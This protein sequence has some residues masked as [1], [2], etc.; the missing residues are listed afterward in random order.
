M[1]NHKNGSM[2]IC[3]FLLITLFYIVAVTIY[4]FNNL[5]ASALLILISFFAYVAFIKIDNNFFSIIALLSLSLFF[6]LGLATL[7]LI[8]LQDHIWNIKTWISFYM[9]YTFFIFS[10]YCLNSSKKYFITLLT[11]YKIIIKKKGI[12][13][14]SF[15]VLLTLLSLISF[16]YVVWMEGYIPLF[17]TDQFSYAKFGAETSIALF[18]QIS[19]I[20]P[21]LAFY[22]KSNK[23]YSMLERKI[24]EI[25]I[26]L[27]L[28]IC[29]F[30]KS[31]DFLLGAAIIFIISII[32]CLMKKFKNK[33]LKLKLKHKIIVLIL[34]ILVLFL[35]IYVTK[36]RN[37][38][39][40]YIYSLYQTKN[41]NIPANIVSFYTYI[42]M[43]YYNFDNM[44]SQ[45]SHYSFGLKQLNPFI[46]LLH[47]NEIKLEVAN[48]PNYFI[49]NELNLYGY[50]GDAYYDFGILGVVLSGIISGWIYSFFEKFYFYSQ[51]SYALVLYA[52]AIHHCILFFFTSWLSNFQYFI[53][54]ILL[55][56]MNF[57]DQSKHIIS[58][59][60]K[61]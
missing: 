55:L 44:V 41:K 8:G 22:E 28:I 19:V 17:S 61:S 49:Q 7:K 54:I 60:E 37:Y 56:T 21:G 5:A 43:G 20:L 58:Q 18:Y 48:L 59:L 29:V 13:I 38:S 52:I 26:F 27:N 32:F 46:I 39:S 24:L 35:F 2:I 50:L 53:Y 11:K 12:R 47:L 31:R 51:R 36:Q 14:Y 15:I 6:S 10:N 30:L 1:E 40:D 34:G 33:K 45:I 16:T 25:C 42:T 3:C 4:Y 9:F 57:F 23:T